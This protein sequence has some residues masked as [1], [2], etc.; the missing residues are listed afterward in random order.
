M[1]SCRLQILP[2]YVY[3]LH[4]FLA[5]FYEFQAI[6]RCLLQVLPDFLIKCL[7]IRS[8][9]SLFLHFL[10]KFH[11]LVSLELLDLEE[12]IPFLQLSQFKRYFFVL[13]NRIY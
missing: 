1:L 9:L 4:F 3:Q 6:F 12:L 13:V 7:S 10:I 5:K 2:Y 11:C 8:I